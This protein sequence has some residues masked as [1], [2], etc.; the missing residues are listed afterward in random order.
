MSL[1]IDQAR[2]GGQVRAMPAAPCH[3]HTRQH[4]FGFLNARERE[5]LTLV[6][7]RSVLKASLAGLAGLTLPGLL[8]LRAASDASA[9]RR[10]MTRSKAVILLWMTGGPSHIDTWDPKPEMPSEIRGPFG[11]VPTKLP[12]VRVCEYLPDRKSTR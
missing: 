2:C 11:V 4:A 9:S 6:S 3:T 7:R 12:G 1:Q 5:G 8:R 10:R